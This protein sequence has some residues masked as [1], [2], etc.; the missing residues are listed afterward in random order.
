MNKYSKQTRLLVAVDCIIF[1]F[2]GAD[3][4]ILLV[5]RSLEP[6]SGKWSLMGGF[7]GANESMDAAA[8]RVLLKLTGLDKVY[9][10]QLHTFGDPGRDPIE[11]TISVTYFSLLDLTKY[12]K[13]LSTE[14]NAEWFPLKKFPQLIFD[15]NKMVQMARAKL[16]YKASLHP[17]LFELLSDKFTIPQLQSLF[18]E[19]YNTSFDKRNFSRKILSTGLLLKLNEKDKTNSKRGAFYYKLDK[20]HYKANFHR[21]LHFIPNPNEFL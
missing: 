20:K 1:G 11:R 7:V 6:E 2:D 19:V 21:I 4:K 5:K 10:E 12:K 13:Q 16:R 18:E 8:N 17:I 14:F 15:H 9:L 3:L